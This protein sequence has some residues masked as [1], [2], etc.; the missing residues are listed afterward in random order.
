MV[1]MIIGVGIFAS[2]WQ[3]EWTWLSRFGALLIILAMLFKASGIADRYLKTVLAKEICRE[4]V[5]MQ[6]RRQPHM[7][8]LKGNETDL[9]IKQIAEKELNRRVKDEGDLLWRIAS[10]EKVT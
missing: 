6:V 7:Y 9:Q 2:I 10:K 8:S 4:I 1:I 5:N 3:H